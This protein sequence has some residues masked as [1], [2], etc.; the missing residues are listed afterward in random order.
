[1]RNHWMIGSLLACVCGAT[2]A[3]GEPPVPQPPGGSGAV[4]DGGKAPELTGAAR[5][6]ADAPR[7]LPM[8]ESRLARVFARAA[9][10]LPSVSPRTLWV[11]KE[12]RAWYTPAERDAL[13]EAERAALAER[14]CDEE[15]YYTTRYGSPLA[16]ARALDVLASRA[17]KDFDDFRGKRIIDYGYGTIGHLR[18]MASLG[19]HCIGIETDTSLAKLYNQPGDTGIIPGWAAH[20]LHEVVAVPDGS[21]RLLTGRFPVDP[22]CTP[23]DIKPLAPE[24]VDL[25]ISKNTLKNGYIHPSEPV[26]KRMLVD[27]GTGEAAFLDAVHGVL[28]PDGW[29]LIYN[30]SPAP[31][32][33]GEKY[34]PWS[35]GRCP[36]SRE[37]LE[38]A[39][40]EV[41]VF[42]ENDDGAARK[43]G[44]ALGWD[45]DGMDLA[46][47]LF[48][49][50]TLARRIDI[51]AK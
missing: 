49:H 13:P 27:L 5:I 19:A 4:P 38:N 29:F 16:Y 50:W 36:F 20:G 34:K 25:F 14:P 44:A 12:K 15:F 40:F 43:L 48:A 26:D 47:D 32:K 6:K 37:Q 23:A 31:S 41:L 10:G 24:G 21:I 35:D 3:A 33:P 1:V 22:G 46:N 9:E 2:L 45:K 51:K 17:G 18:I 42:D 8:L 39:G 28:H 11:N 7:L 30:L